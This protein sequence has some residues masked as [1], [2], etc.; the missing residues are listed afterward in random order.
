MFNK[1]VI[2]EM[3]IDAVNDYD[4]ENVRISRLVLETLW[5]HFLGKS[6]KL[7]DAAGDVDSI[8]EGVKELKNDWSMMIRHYESFRKKVVRRVGRGENDMEEIGG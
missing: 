4:G 3:E 5:I 2:N 6:F 7:E 1:E 8:L